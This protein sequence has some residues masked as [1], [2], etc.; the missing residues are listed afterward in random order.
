MRKWIT[1]AGTGLLVAG[2]AGACT[3]ER[4]NV[5]KDSTGVGAPPAAAA[6]PAAPA[7][8]GD[9]ITY[10][11]TLSGERYSPLDQITTANVTRLK[12]VCAFD[13]PD[14]VSLQSGI[15]AVNGT[16]YF[17][18]FNNTYAFDGATCARKWSQTRAEP[19]TYLKVNRGL[20]YSDG[21]L[22]RGTGDAHV[23]G[24]DAATGRLLW[25]VS[26]GNPKIGESTPLAP[27]AWSGLVFA[28]NAGGDNFDVR[29]RIYALDAA[30]GRVVWEFHTIP[31]SGAVRATWGKASA[32]NPPAGGATWTS[33]ALDEA[34][35]ILY[36]STGNPAPDFVEAFH[37]GLNL[38]S[39]TVLALNARTGRL[40]AYVQPIHNDFHDWD[41]S[42]P[43]ALITTAGGHAFIGQ[44]AKDGNVYGID[45][46]AVSAAASAPDTAA[47]AVRYK[48]AVSTRINAETPL[49]SDRM[50]RFCP[51]SQGGVE[52]NGPAFDR[53]HGLLVVNSIDWCTS[54]KLQRLDTLKGAPG[55]AW[56]GM[57]DPQM[58]FGRLDPVSQWRGWITAVDA[59]N[60]QIRWHVK[61]PKPMVAGITATAGG[62]VFTGDL[63]GNVL[64]L[65]AATGKELWRDA[66]GK[67]IGG[68]V[69]SFQAGG[70]QYVAAAA[71][72][73]SAIWPVHGGSAQ[74]VVYGL[75]Q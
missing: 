28:G 62:L 65:D 33:Y 17:T 45:R 12:R 74:V 34:K 59:E 26:I 57:D 10:N 63:D 20:G 7:A 6:S 40:L 4:R 29:G 67:A 9:W 61:T 51:G 48:A 32:A 43:P 69:I 27:I 23:L 36:V 70:R 25:D 58:A 5:A 42:A 37:P 31:D 30:T 55:Q 13:A 49:T 50:T 15:L 54:V 16:L 22:F 18:A 11:G 3:G 14:S 72:L 47:L 38:Y 1:R 64:A 68:G 19:A 35:G 53:R 39:N 2:L 66:T 52:W 41:V 8:P 44:A 71:G 21:R 24:L 60:G 56:S 46:S 73:N 75:P